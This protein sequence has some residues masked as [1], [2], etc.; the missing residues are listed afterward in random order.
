MSLLARFP[1]MITVVGYLLVVEYL[2]LSMS[3]NV[4]Y[5]FIAVA[6]VAFMIEMFKS[7]DVGVAGFFWD[8]FWALVTVMLATSLLTFLYFVAGKEPT[9]YHWV[10]LGVIVADALLN[11]ANAYRTA[12]RNFDVPN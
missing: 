7:G 11:P 10:G 5:G 1:W 3:G 9:F 6:L 2:Q 12:M 8:Q 4:G